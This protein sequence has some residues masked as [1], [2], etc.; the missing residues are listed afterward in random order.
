M[1]IANMNDRLATPLAGGFEPPTSGLDVGAITGTRPYLLSNGRSIQLA[2]RVATAAAKQDAQTKAVAP[3]LAGQADY[4]GGGETLV[5]AYT[6]GPSGAN[7]AIEY[8][9]IF[10]E[11]GPDGFPAELPNHVAP[12]HVIV[13]FTAFRYNG[14]A[15]DGWTYGT[16]AFTASAAAN[17]AGLHHK[18][19]HC[20][21]AP[22]HVPWDE[23]TA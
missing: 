6:A 2:A 13:A 17:V 16:D 18:T 11:K 5:V 20:D 4:Q 15:A 21:Q 8:E 12:E 23:V 7:G 22:G 14:N 19:F 10:S 1:T 9:T 3:T